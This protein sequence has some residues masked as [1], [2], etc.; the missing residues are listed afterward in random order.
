[1]ST[2]HKLLWALIM[3]VLTAILYLA[4]RGYLSPAMLIDFA[5]SFY[6]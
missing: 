2:T 3:A 4:F 6:C 5:N 1:M